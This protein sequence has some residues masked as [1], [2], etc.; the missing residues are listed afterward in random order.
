MLLEL[1]ET[2]SRGPPTDRVLAAAVSALLALVLG[3]GDA[4]S[5][6]R[7]AHTLLQLKGASDGGRSVAVSVPAIAVTV[8]QTVRSMLGLPE[9]LAYPTAF[10]S[11]QS[12]RLAPTATPGPDAVA[13]LASDGTYLYLLR[14]SR[15]Q[16]MRIGRGSAAD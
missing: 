14:P 4:G 8:E 11:P 5:I 1:I 7:V 9:G 16:V 10:N 2:A 15:L 13:S 12:Y 6:V 3:R